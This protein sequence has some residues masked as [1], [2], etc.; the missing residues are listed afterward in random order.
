MKTKIE[1]A[2]RPQDNS[3]YMVPIHFISI[4]TSLRSD[5][6]SYGRGMI[7]WKTMIEKTSYKHICT[8]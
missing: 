3:A 1:E 4:F 5:K 6:I 2:L 8:I 7:F